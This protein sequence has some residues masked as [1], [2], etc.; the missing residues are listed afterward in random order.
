MGKKPD[1]D[2]SRTV[3][4]FSGN[5]LGLSGDVHRDEKDKDTDGGSSRLRVRWFADHT[6]VDSQIISL[7]L[8][9]THW[10]AC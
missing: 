10:P 1:G 3:L 7:S 4:S 6:S 2:M 5:N 9:L 8:L